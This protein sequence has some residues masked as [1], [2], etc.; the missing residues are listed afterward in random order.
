MTNQNDTEANSDPIGTVYISIEGKQATNAFSLVTVEG[1]VTEPE[2]TQPET[3]QPDTT[4]LETNQ[5]EA[6][7]PKVTINNGKWKTTQFDGYV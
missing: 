1:D 4:Q 6:C 2:A 7:V 5:P 3:T